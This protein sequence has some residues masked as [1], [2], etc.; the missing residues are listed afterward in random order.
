M[1]ILD[2]FQAQGLNQAAATALARTRIKPTVRAIMSRQQVRRTPAAPI[3]PTGSF[4][5][6]AAGVSRLIRCHQTHKS[7]ASTSR[8]RPRDRQRTQ[9]GVDHLAPPVVADLELY[10]TRSTARSEGP[11]ARSSP[12]RPGSSWPASRMAPSSAASPVRAKRWEPN[13]LTIRG[14]RAGQTLG[15]GRRRARGS[16]RGRARPK[17]FWHSLRAG[18]ACSAES[19]SAMC[20]AT[21]PCLSRN[22]PPLSTP[23]RQVPRQ[24]HQGEWA[25]GDREKP[26][27][28]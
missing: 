1:A 14:W 9:V 17:V 20:K 10:A 13:G 5:A 8:P 26:L 27:P 11:T 28:F 24:P 23:Q 6:P 25:V 22:D 16:S 3:P 19:T 15:L 4:F 2:S 12:R 7:S 21:R 18:L